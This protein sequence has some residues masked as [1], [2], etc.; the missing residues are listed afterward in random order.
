MGGLEGQKGS[1]VPGGIWGV[2]WGVLGVRKAL[3]SHGGGSGD[4]MGGSWGSHGE[5]CG[6]PMGGLG[7]PMGGVWGSHRGVLGVPWG[8]VGWRQHLCVVV[9]AIDAELRGAGHHQVALGRAEEMAVKAELQ[10]RRGVGLLVHRVHGAAPLPPHC[11]PTAAPQRPYSCPTAAPQRPYNRTAVPA[12]DGSAPGGKQ[13][14]WG[15]W[16]NGTHAKGLLW[17][18]PHPTAPH[19]YPG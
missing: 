14:D 8:A 6:G 10:T 3:G 11:R 16:G 7:G 13:R 19:R 2:P 4:P 9:E 15:Q 17:G 5:G 18:C 1:G 12:S